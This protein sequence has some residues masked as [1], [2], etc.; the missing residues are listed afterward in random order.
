[1]SVLVADGAGLHA[2]AATT[3]HSAGNAQL[4]V[5]AAPIRQDTGA[6]DTQRDSRLPRADYQQRASHHLALPLGEDRVGSGKS[7][8]H[9]LF[10]RADT[11]ATSGERPVS[12]DER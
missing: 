5:S 7:R 4:L 1:M 2:T 11:R 3:F 10:V 9:S 8:R 6:G 12:V